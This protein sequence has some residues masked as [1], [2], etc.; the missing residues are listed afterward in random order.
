MNFLKYITNNEKSSRDEVLFD[1]IFFII[2]TL[3]LLIAIPFFIIKGEAQWL[4]ALVIEYT[5]AL[6]NL[7]NNRDDIRKN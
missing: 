2:N 5:W 4:S 7:R 6:D 1:E 3:A